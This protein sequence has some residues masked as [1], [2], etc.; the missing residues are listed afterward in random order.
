MM[1]GL[2][3]GIS[4]TCRRRI[5]SGLTFVKLGWQVWHSVT[6]TGMI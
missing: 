6:G 4:V 3:G 5:L 1:N 2:T